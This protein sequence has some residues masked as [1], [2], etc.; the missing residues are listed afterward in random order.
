M[1][2]LFARFGSWVVA[3]FAA[4]GVGWA[5]SDIADIVSGDSPTNGNNSPKWYQS[6]KNSLSSIMPLWLVPVIIAFVLGLIAYKLGLF[7]R[8]NK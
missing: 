4:L 3:N 5:A 7:K 6:L 2:G 1:F 8:K